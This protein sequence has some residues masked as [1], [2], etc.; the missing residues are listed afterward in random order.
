MQIKDSYEHP[1]ES[2]GSKDAASTPIAAV[3]AKLC[4]H[5]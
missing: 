2:S 5:D 4:L 1:I 3:N